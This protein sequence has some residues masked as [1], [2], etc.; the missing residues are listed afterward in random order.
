MATTNQ[1]GVVMSRD[2][3]GILLDDKDQWW[4]ECPNSDM[5][6]PEDKQPQ[7]CPHCG[8]EIGPK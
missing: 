2:D 4:V 5:R 6:I 1:R 7:F 3:H 8:E